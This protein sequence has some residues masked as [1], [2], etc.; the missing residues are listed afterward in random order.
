MYRRPQ[1][2]RAAAGLGGLLLA[3][4][5]PCTAAQELAAGADASMAGFYGAYPMS[6]EGSGTSWQPE[7]TP[8]SGL[9]QM[10]G[11]WMQMV[12][13]FVNLIYDEQGGPRGATKTFSSSM[14][15]S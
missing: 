2:A 7:S 14:R 15:V 5:L 13:G 3:A 8:L 9:Q 10:S 1:R 11:P 12:H 6:R 4:Y